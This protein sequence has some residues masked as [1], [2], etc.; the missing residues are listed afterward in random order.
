MFKIGNP[1]HEQETIDKL[2][3]GVVGAVEADSYASHMLWM[4]FAEDA[5]KYGSRERKRYSWKQGGSGILHTAGCID[6]DEAKPV[7][8]SLFVNEVGGHRILFYHTTSRYVDHDI[9]RGWLEAQL[10]EQ[11]MEP[12]RGHPNFTDAMNFPNVLHAADR[13]VKVD[14]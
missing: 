11:C 7:C 10:G 2:L 13:M 3:E 9:V 6:G 4:E 8:L 5:E 12:R 1:C 14:A